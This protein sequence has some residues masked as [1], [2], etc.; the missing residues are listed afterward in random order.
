MSR[1]TNVEA[2]QLDNEF[3]PSGTTCRCDN[4]QSRFRAWLRERYGTVAELNRCWG[5]GFWSMDYT[6]WSQIGLGGG[7][8]YVSRILDSIASGRT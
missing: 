1:H 4:C 5:T 3:G 8:E 2:W 6:E 7:Y